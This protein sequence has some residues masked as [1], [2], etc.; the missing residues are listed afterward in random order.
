MKEMTLLGSSDSK[1][2]ID[3]LT[4]LLNQADEKVKHIDDRRQTSLNYALAIF[5]GLIGLGIGLNNLSYRLYISVS[6]FLIMFLFSLWDRRLHKA[7][8]GVQASRATFS[9]KILE[10]INNPKK[11]ITVPTYRSDCEKNAEWFSLLPT[12]FYILTLCGLIS[13]FLF[14]FS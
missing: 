2:R 3:F 14:L 4:T 6:L 1:Q 5:A 7:S 9:E 11:D 10:M 13:F 12:I 8:H